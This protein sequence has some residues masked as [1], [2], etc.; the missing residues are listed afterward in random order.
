[1]IAL[2]W[3]VAMLLLVVAVLSGAAVRRQGEVVETWDEFAREHHIART[4][5]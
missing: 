5:R 1:M 2:D 4:R 3:A